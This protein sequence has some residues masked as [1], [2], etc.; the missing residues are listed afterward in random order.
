M[1][2]C[3][4]VVLDIS[5]LVSAALCTGSIPDQILSKALESFELCASVEKDVATANAAVMIEARTAAG[6]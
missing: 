6:I 2:R 4:R 1:R 5:V 3:M